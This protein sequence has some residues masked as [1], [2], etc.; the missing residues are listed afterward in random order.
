MEK[1]TCR[2]S[3]PCKVDMLRQCLGR[4]QVRL[5]KRFFYPCGNL[6]RRY[7][8]CN[9]IKPFD[10]CS[11]SAPEESLKELENVLRMSKGMDSVILIDIF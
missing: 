5:F 2:R 3:S 10:R 1:V 9:L 8:C 4:E 6:N 7:V 11:C